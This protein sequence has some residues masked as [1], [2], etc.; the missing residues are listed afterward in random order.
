MTGLLS[1]LRE[2][3]F[4]YLYLITWKWVWTA[5]KDI[6]FNIIAYITNP[7]V[8]LFTDKYG[9]LPHSLRYWQTYDNCLDVE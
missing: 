9:N 7:I 1:Q 5:F 2:K 4:P 8:V 3:V 6:L